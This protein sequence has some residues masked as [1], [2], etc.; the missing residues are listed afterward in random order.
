MFRNNK[1][2]ILIICFFVVLII[3]CSAIFVAIRMKNKDSSGGNGS[4]SSG[5]HSD[6]LPVKPGTSSS[7][8]KDTE[9]RE[10]D[11]ESREKDTGSQEKDTE[12]GKKNA[13][14]L[15]FR[16]KAQRDQ[17]YQ[18]HGKEMGFPSPEAYL[19]GANEVVNDPSSLHKTEK[20]DGD[21]VYYRERDNAF[22]VVSTDGYIRTF[23]Y[24]NG[25]KA[26][27]DRQ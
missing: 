7:Q 5:N 25:G 27:F 20:E 3:A 23:F 12:S 4:S 18:K 22:V 1:R 6:L 21:D 24:P 8:E 2:I 19:D 16:T 26:Y 13:E 9:S 10:K 17:H 11:T 14:K 15:W